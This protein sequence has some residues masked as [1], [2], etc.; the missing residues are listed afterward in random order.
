[1]NLDKVIVADIETDGLLDVTTKLH[2]FAFGVKQPDGKWKV[3]ATNN[4]KA[5]IKAFSNPENV[6]VMHNGLRFD[7]PALEK[8]YGIK[9]KATIIDSLSLSWWLFPTRKKRYGL[10]AFGEDY[11]IEKPPISDWSTL[12]YEEYKHRCM[13][14]VEINI[15]LWEDLLRKGRMFYNT[16]EKFIKL[17]SLLN[18][19][20]ECSYNQEKQK[21]KVDVDKTKENLARFELMK[22]EKLD[23]LI[24]AMP[25]A[26]KSVTKTKPKVCYKKGGG[27]S[28][29]GEKWFELLKENDLPDTTEEVTITIEAGDPNPNSVTQKKDWLYSLGWIPETFEYKRNKETGEVKKIEQIVNKDTK[30]LCPSVLKLKEKE[31]AIEAFDGLTVLTHRIGVLKGFLENMDEDGYI[32]QGLIK[33][34]VTMRWQHS[35]IVNIPKV[36]GRGDIRDGKW[37]R[38]CLIAQ[39]GTTLVQADLSGVESRT[40]DHYTFKINPDRIEKTKMPYFD[41]HTEISVVAGLMTPEEEAFYVYNSSK[42]DAEAGGEDTSTFDYKNFSFYPYNEEI[43]RL[44]DLPEADKKTLMQDIKNKRSRGKTTNYASLYLVGAETLSRNL[45]ITKKEAQELINAYWEVHWAVKVATSTFKTKVVD[46]ETWIYNPVSKFWYYLR[47]EK[48]KFSVINQSTAVYCFNMWVYFVTKRVGFPI[49][50]T[51]DDLM[52][53]VEDNEEAVSHTMI[54]IKR[55]M[56]DVNKCLKLNV[57][58]D[59]EVQHGYNFAETH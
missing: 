9:V 28:A 21:V 48:D 47:N 36:T 42:K 52:L 30:M 50:Q 8:I 15:R 39:E 3:D 40:S 5:I 6:F 58:L 11:G 18:F 24:S 59:C 44:H 2:V 14:D 29:A 53:R 12:S 32:S 54:Q 27:L 56:E 33:L 35:T 25:K 43:Q 41:A 7:K 13:E 17:L 57:L 31:P 22:E 10:E 34:A 49:T 20:M 45:Q 38:E 26:T 1:M 51:H 37:L 46:G 4:H 19:I 55:A 16:D 23:V